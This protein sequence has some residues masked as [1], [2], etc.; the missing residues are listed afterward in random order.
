M[1]EALELKERILGKIIYE[2]AIYERI[3]DLC[4]MGSRF[5]GTKSEKDAQQY[6][7][8][9]LMVQ[10]I[11]A[12]THE[13]EYQGWI[14]GECSFD[15]KSSKYQKEFSAISLVL[16]PSTH[17]ET[18]EGHIIDGKGGSETELN[19]IKDSIPG[20]ILMIHSGDTEE[21]WLHRR[22]KYA[23]AVDFGAKVFVFANHNPGQ[24]FPTGSVRSNRIGEIPAIGI[25]KETYELVKEIIT[26][27]D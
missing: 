13:F 16:A 5:S 6:M 2:D 24:L 23:N 15:I 22:I 10:G 3:K 20:K 17:G 18:V 4:L 1:N 25:S 7:L 19:R 14:R 11:D 8:N 26:K 12:F 21:G 9:F 27:E